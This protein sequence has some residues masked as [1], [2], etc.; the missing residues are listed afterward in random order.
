MI[1]KRT[2]EK[3]TLCAGLLSSAMVLISTGTSMTIDPVH[4][5]H[6]IEMVISG[7]LVIFVREIIKCPHEV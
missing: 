3:I 7:I 5:F 4:T 2:R 6:G 1:E